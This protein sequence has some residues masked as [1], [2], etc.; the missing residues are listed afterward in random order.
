LFVAPA[1]QSVE[2]LV[3]KNAG[4]E[5]N[6]YLAAIIEAVIEGRTSQTADLTQ[7][8]V[9]AGIDPSDIFTKAITPAMTE[10]GRLMERNEYYVPEVLMAAKAT[11]TASAILKPLLTK[12]ED[13]TEAGTVVIGTVSG[14]MHDIGKN[15]VIIM[16]EGAGF[17]V[18]DLGVDVAP[19]AFIEAT[20]KNRANVV[21]MSALLTTTML[22]MREVV[23]ALTEAGLRDQVKI[24]IGGA[25]VEKAFAD[26]IGAD[27]FAP[28]AAAGTKLA[29]NLVD[30]H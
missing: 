13:T 27:G 24:I 6:H 19:E 11:K 25:P 20:K 30:G 9:D 21:A 4:T 15:L 14:D 17:K 8:A 29:L 5:D 18:V 16:L 23:A 7:E 10:V 28:N 1:E 12:S 26:E 2:E 3:I 22:N